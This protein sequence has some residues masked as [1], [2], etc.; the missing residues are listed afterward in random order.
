MM[1]V[2][3]AMSYALRESF[4]LPAL[5]QS[6]RFFNHSQPAQSTLR[7]ASHNPRLSSTEQTRV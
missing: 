4:R 7:T 1:L 6:A 5:G 3:I 2:S